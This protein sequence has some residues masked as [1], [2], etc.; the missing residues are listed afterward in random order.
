M[1]TKIIKILLVKIFISQIGCSEIISREDCVPG[2]NYESQYFCFYQNIMNES[3]I[4]EKII[5]NIFIG[6]ALEKNKIFIEPF[7][8]DNYN[9][10]ENFKYLNVPKKINAIAIQSSSVQ[11][12]SGNY[13][14][15]LKKYIPNLYKN[16]Y[17]FNKPFSEPIYDL[18]NFQINQEVEINSI[19]FGIFEYKFDRFDCSNRGK[20]RPYSKEEYTK[21]ISNLK[22][23][24]E[25][26]DRTLDFKK[27]DETILNARYI[28]SLSDSKS[29]TSFI[30]SS[31]ETKG[32]EYAGTVYLVD[33]FNKNKLIKTIEKYNYDGPY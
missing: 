25:T 15:H 13:K 31:Y 21:A 27:I 23:D 20:K 12:I 3:R 33:F 16:S 14:E 4:D 26:K 11:N 6:E 8:F 30:L 5:K 18:L 32:F 24:H 29:N 19:I 22:E 10:S 28:C 9:L 2:F 7:D 1:N 17:F